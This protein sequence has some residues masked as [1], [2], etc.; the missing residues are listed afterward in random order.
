[1]E[2]STVFGL[3]GVIVNA[4]WPLIKHR[5]HLL[6]GQVLACIFMFAHFWLIGAHTGAAVMA[7][8][9]IQA[10]LAIPLESHP[11]FK[12]VYFAS[13]LLTPL[14]AWLSWHGLPSI[15][16]TLALVFFCMGNLQISTK[17][18]RILL[19]FCLFCWVGHN[20]LISSYPAL[21][22]NFI[23]LCSSIYGL[24]REF[25]PNKSRQKDAQTA[26]ASA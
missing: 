3:S 16:S 20:L 14:V 2:L 5:K 7:V 10:A 19:L 11:K 22:S 6:S 21:A 12:S 25:M 24:S 18:L 9:G 4:L 15:L 13:L 1:M 23:A 17:R 26:R 8:A